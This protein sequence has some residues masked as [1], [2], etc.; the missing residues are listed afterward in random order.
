MPSLGSIRRNFSAA[1]RRGFSQLTEA[2]CD[3]FFR[4]QNLVAPEETAFY[5][6]HDL[7]VFLGEISRLETDHLVQCPVDCLFLLDLAYFH[8]MQDF[9][10]RMD[11]VLEIIPPLAKRSAL[12]AVRFDCCLELR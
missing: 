6:H 8:P 2:F 10:Q 3:N 4:P 5:A 11:R 9:R 12:A 1:C 7:A